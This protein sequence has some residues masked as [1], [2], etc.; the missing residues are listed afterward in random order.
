MSMVVNCSTSARTLVYHS[1][2]SYRLA[3]QEQRNG[4]STT[5]FRYS[6]PNNP[7][8]G[9]TGHRQRGMPMAHYQERSNLESTM[10]MIKA[11]V[12]GL[13]EDQDSYRRGE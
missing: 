1:N 7:D 13:R 3:E 4:H 6:R 11:R 9:D 5:E 12:G 8:D 10:F 2:C